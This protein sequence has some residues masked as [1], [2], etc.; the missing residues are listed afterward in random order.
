MTEIVLY[1]HPFSRAAGVVWML[2][3]LGRP[4]RLEHV[5][6][7]KGEQKSERLRALNPMGKIPI[8]VDGETIVTETAAIGIYLADRYAPGR[9]APA[10]DASQRG[11]F[12]RACVFPS[13]VIEPASLAK[14]KGWEVPTG[15]AGFGDY[16]SMVASL[17]SLLADGPF[18]LGETFS[19]ADTILGGTVRWMLRFDML[20]ATPRLTQYAQRLGERPALQT[21]EAKNAAI[22]AE[23][24]LGR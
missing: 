3:E 10:L 18:V 24:K 23:R 1:H 21:A 15:Q 11:K 5:E 8:L 22:I 12:L 4:Y 13:A 19:I 6:L 14:M 17:E 7:T 2:E 9:L 16:D 20:P